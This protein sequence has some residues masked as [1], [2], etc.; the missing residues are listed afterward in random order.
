VFTLNFRPLY[1]HD[2]DAL[3]IPGRSGMTEEDVRLNYDALIDYN[4]PFFT[5]ELRFPTLPM[6]EPG[7]I[8]F[9]EVKRI[10]NIFYVLFAVSL[11]G[12]IVMAVRLFRK[13]RTKFLK[14]G[15]I[16]AVAIPAALGLLLAVAGWNKAFVIL[17]QLMF[18][19]DYWIF[20]SAVDPVILILP[21]AFFMHCLY[22]ILGLI[23]SFAAA[24]F[25]VGSASGVVPK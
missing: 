8:H 18:N 19:N 15:A 1:Y 11:V 23:V 25:A 3:D 22:L 14:L 6:S 13:R 16:F 20:D 2:M 21:D 17:H 7:R 9:E 4:T 12:S 10:F 5:G 24:A